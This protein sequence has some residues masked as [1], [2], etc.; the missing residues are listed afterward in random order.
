M[1]PEALVIVVIFVF[2][3]PFL[4]PNE[5]HPVIYFGQLGMIIFGYLYYLKKS[6]YKLKR[7][8]PIHE[9]QDEEEQVLISYKSE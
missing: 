3:Y 9:F 7:T 2:C 1:H 8:S 5:H 4:N 6:L